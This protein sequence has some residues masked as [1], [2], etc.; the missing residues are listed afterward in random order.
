MFWV[1]TPGRSGAVVPGRLSLRQVAPT[2]AAL[3]GLPT[4]GLF[5][6]PPLDLARRH[7]PALGTAAE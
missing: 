4:Q 1:R 3:I 6:L 2:L 7:A 5:A